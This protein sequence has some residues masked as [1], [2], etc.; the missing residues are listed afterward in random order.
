MAKAFN[1]IINQ[2][3]LSEYNVKIKD[4]EYNLYDAIK[5][6]DVKPAIKKYIDIFEQSTSASNTTEQDTYKPPQFNDAI[7]DN[8]EC[9]KDIIYN[10]NYKQET[11]LKNALFY[12]KWHNQNKE[13]KIYA[14]GYKPSNYKYIQ[15]LGNLYFSSNDF[16]ILFR[17]EPFNTKQFYKLMDI[18]YND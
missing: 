1:P 16:F 3:K 14:Y 6:K 7:I 15:Q 17:C 5:K 13:V 2:P 4:L 10:K 9:E 18:I 8:L 11:Y 12:I